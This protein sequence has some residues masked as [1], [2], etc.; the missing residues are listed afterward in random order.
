M[1][2]Y[3]AVLRSLS[4]F[5][6]S[7]WSVVTLAH[8]ADGWLDDEVQITPMHTKFITHHKT[9]AIALAAC[10]QVAAEHGY[11]NH[12]VG[13]AYDNGY[14]A[15]QGGWFAIDGNKSNGFVYFEG[16]YEQY[17]VDGDPDKSC[18]TGANPC[19]LATGEK[20]Q[21]EV[22]YVGGGDFPIEVT[23]HYSSFRFNNP[24]PFGVGWGLN[25][26]QGIDQQ[27]NRDNFENKRSKTRSR[28]FYTPEDACTKG[29]IEV[30]R[31]AVGGD[32]R[33]ATATFNS[34]TGLCEVEKNGE[35]VL[36]LVVHSNGPW[37]GA[38]L[39]KN[40]YLLDAG[41]NTKWFTEQ[42]AEWV[43]ERTPN[44]RML[45][46]GQG[47]LI[48]KGAG[49]SYY[50]SD[51]RLDRKEDGSGNF[52]IYIYD[53]S[54]ALGGDGDAKT[55]DRIEHSAGYQVSFAYTNGSLT[56][57]S[58]PAGDFAYAYDENGNLVTVSKPDGE[59]RQYL[60]EVP[61]LPNHLTGI[62]DENADRYSTWSYN[63]YSGQVTS[64]YHGSNVDKYT[65]S[66][67]SRGN[68][69]FS[70]TKGETSN[71]VFDIIGGQSRIKSVSGDICS[72]CNFQTYPQ[73]SYN[74]MGQVTQKTDWEGGVTK[75]EYT[76]GFKTKTTEAFGEPEERVT[77]TVWDESLGLPIAIETADKLIA[78]VY[79]A[80][81]KLTSR[82]TTDKATTLSRVETYSYDGDGRLQSYDGSRT[83]V[84]DTIT[85]EYDL[86]GLLDK[87]TNALGH[88]CRVLEYTNDGRPQK[89]ADAN[90]VETS[91]T[92]NY[93]GQ[94][95]SS[96]TSSRVTS[97]GYDGVGQLTSITYP[98]GKVSTF[99][100]DSAHRLT[101]VTDSAGN[102]TIYTLDDYSN[103]TKTEFKNSQGD[104]LFSQTYEYNKLNRLL[105]SISGED[106][107]ETSYAYD[108][109]GNLTQSTDALN[110]V[111]TREYDALNQV[112][113]MVDGLTQ[114]TSFSHDEDGQLTGVTDP[115]N[116]TTSYTYNGFGEVTQL[117]SPDTGVTTYE[118]D[119]AGNR[120]AQVDAR[121]VRTEYSYDALNRL[122][123]V[124][125]PSDSSLDVTY[126]YDQGTN[127]IGRLTRID[128][129]TGYTTYGYDAWGNVTSQT[130]VTGGHTYTVGYSYNADNQLESVAYPSGNVVNYSFS[131]IGNVSDVILTS[132]GTTGNLATGIGYLPFGPSTGWTLGN[133]LVVSRDFDLDYRLTD[134]QTTPIIDFSYGYDPVG[135][136]IQ[137]D[138]LLDTSRSQSFDYDA[139]DR[140]T[141]ATG[142]YGD[143][144]YGYDPVGNRLS[145]TETVS[146]ASDTYAYDPDSNLLTGITG[147]NAESITYDAVGNIVARGTDTFTYNVRNRLAQVERNSAV[148]A[149]YQHNGKGERV[150]KT[151][152]GNTTHFV[153]D[154]MGNI[155][156]EANGAGTVEREYVYVNGE[157]LALLQQSPT[158]TTYYYH[159]DHLGTPKALTNA[160]GT[161]VWQADYTP[162]GELTETVSIVEQPFRFPGQYF[163]GETGLYY[164]YFR[165]YDPE[166]GRYLQSD[167]IGLAGGMNTYAYVGGNPLKYVDPLGLVWVTT[168][169][170]HHGVKNWAI[171]IADRLSSLD[172]GTVMNAYNFEG[173]TRDVTQTWVDHPSDP[174]NQRDYCMPD[175]PMEGDT[176]TIEQTFGNH[177][178]PW[179]VEGN[180]WHWTPPVPSPTWDVLP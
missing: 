105:K 148:I 85:Y 62:V 75:Y 41:G 7:V 43:S 86:N 171:G 122:T 108:A 112:S 35:L 73:V 32:L 129:A 120:T 161:V 118:Y 114:T 156:V 38:N 146:A 70:N 178:D 130:Q 69:K 169:V 82:T 55:L 160:S 152:G 109:L 166:T 168:G 149:Q 131:A 48:K 136:I 49:T 16:W 96:T 134:V 83:D 113:S 36:K 45:T 18:D 68:S 72:G 157:R 111:T 137:W 21:V 132:G 74:A 142:L 100:Y 51:G 24:Q 150:V 25:M 44:S 42:G 40:K 98:S 84:N 176:R 138:N 145:K 177:P 46:N 80:N 30:L 67:A 78:L 66:V 172:E 88:Q 91:F 121:G 147:A 135:N 56:S 1:I 115:N 71:L 139:L 2:R 37:E 54:Q 63:S 110:R 92:Y 27:R 133:G 95:L 8:P 127:G 163:D 103:V 126:T 33:Y 3:S 15:V 93:R 57:V 144:D 104:I 128:D 124:R 20:T 22:D 94:V 173:A 101:R 167:P 116:H 79:D 170:D 59:V 107:A 9:L 47:Y 52:Q 155:I 34:S 175:D 53:L 117:T 179:A 180:S 153:Y 39:P 64:S 141:D 165:D 162:F 89:I 17:Y 28:L 11:T 19:V 12:C 50:G 99:E 61:S 26:P 65:L 102:E 97:Y 29:A 119:E 143:F 125:Y 151:A 5:L 81:G 159:N 76:N 77:D 4:F 58:T 87:V 123:Q 90:L 23:R 154:L 31:S 10:N 158:Q 140:L 164:N 106:V 6:F 14:R 60:Y 13:G 174:Q